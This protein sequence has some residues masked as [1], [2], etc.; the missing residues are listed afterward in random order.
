MTKLYGYVRMTMVHTTAHD[1]MTTMSWALSHKSGPQDLDT[2]AIIIALVLLSL[3][4]I[5]KSGLHNTGV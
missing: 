4:P 5:L 3:G 1:I 2:N